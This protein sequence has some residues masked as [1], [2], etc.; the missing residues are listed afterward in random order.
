ME[1]NIGVELGRTYYKA[2]HTA[3]QKRVPCTVCNGKLVVT[4]IDGYDQQWTI[5]C[6]ACAKGYEGPR[7]YEHEY[8]YTPNAEPF[9]PVKLASIHG[10]SIYVSDL[11]GTQIDVKYLHETREEAIAVSEFSLK[12]MVEENF[13]RSA[14][15]TRH[16]RKE[17]AWSVRYHNDCL[18]RLRQQVEWHESKVRAKK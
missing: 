5:E 17:K 11:L 1:L 16:S 18:K 15:S 4:L 7:G 13:R 8:D 2:Q 10:D 3:V 9:T 6:E 14:H 12:A